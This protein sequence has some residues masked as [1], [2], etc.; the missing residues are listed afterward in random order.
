MWLGYGNVGGCKCNLGQFI[1]ISNIDVKLLI[2]FVL[3]MV[4]FLPVCH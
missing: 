1:E 4:V 2:L 3:I